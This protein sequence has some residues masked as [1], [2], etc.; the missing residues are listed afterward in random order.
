MKESKKEDGEWDL[1]GSILECMK[2]YGKY[3]SDSEMEVILQSLEDGIGEDDIK[4]FFALHDIEK[5]RKYRKAFL[6]S[7]KNAGH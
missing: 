5:M 3:L 1:S 7:K 4:T 2:R 6:F